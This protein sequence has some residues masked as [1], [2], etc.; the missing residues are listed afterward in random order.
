[1]ATNI[2]INYVV[3]DDELKSAD[4]ALKKLDKTTDV[5]KKDVAQLNKKFKDQE[6]QLS[7]NTQ[8][9]SGLKGAIAPLAGVLSVAVVANFTKEL[10]L[11]KGEADGVREAFNRLTGTTLK[12]LKKSVAGTVDELT[13]MKAAVRADQFKIPLQTLAT[14]FEFASKRATQTGQSVG[15]LVDSIIDGIGR[16]SPLI[17]DNLGISATQLSAKFKEL[18]DFGEA[19]AVII[20]EELGNMGEV[21]ENVGSATDRLAAKYDDLKLQLADFVISEGAVGTIEWLS[22]VV[23]KSGDAIIGLQGLAEE[24]PALANSL[25]SITAIIRTSPFGPF[26]AAFDELAEK[27]AEIR[28]KAEKEG[29]VIDVFF[30]LS[31]EEKKKLDEETEKFFAELEKQAEVLIELKKITSER[32]D[33]FSVGFITDTEISKTI[34]NIKTMEELTEEGLRIFGDAEEEKTDIFISNKQ[35]RIDFEEETQRIRE[36]I[37]LQAFALA[38]SQLAAGA[39]MAEEGSGLQQALIV[40]EKIAAITK[41]IIAANV[42]KAAAATAAALTIPF[43]P[44][45][46]VAIAARNAAINTR[47]GLSI[48][49]ITAAAI[50][51]L[52]MHEGGEIKS[53]LG[54]SDVPMIGKAGEFVIKDRAVEHY[55]LQTMEAINNMELTPIGFSDT[56]IVS[57][58]RSLNKSFSSRPI[59]NLVFDQRGFSQ[60]IIKGNNR[61]IYARNRYV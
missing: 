30:G 22:D 2:R 46:L 44:A 11:L 53:P 48:A 58:L 47:T 43:L 42:E 4:K 50:P 24:F 52:V 61:T 7:K 49:A 34:D 17:L 55:G 56:N 10:I 19:A 15:F 41:I 60:S 39:L 20:S 45:Q 26:L 35:K 51:Q 12:E 33:E 28:E 38:E 8:A 9:F 37:A 5:T 32:L 3:K 59:N 36:E 31:P 13:L 1:M 29:G 6:R 16:K 23:D 25:D 27:G 14:L 40:F 57:E 21:S 18:G 54:Y